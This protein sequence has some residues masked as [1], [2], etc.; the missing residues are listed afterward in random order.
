[1]S[2]PQN[3]E[4]AYAVLIRRSKERALLGSCEM[5]LRWDERTY[6]PRGGAEHRAQQRALLAGLV[7]DR[8]TAP[9]I[10]DL[11]SQ[12][13]ESPLAEDPL[14]TTSANIREIRRGYDRMMK[15]PR[16]L[17]EELTR[18]TARAQQAWREARATSTFEMF[19]PHLERVV[20]L[21]RQEAAALSTGRTAYDALLDGYEPGETTAN[22]TRVFELLR[23]ELVHL[24]E[25]IVDSGKGHD[26]SIPKGDYPLDRQEAFGKAAAADGIS[27]GEVRVALW[28]LTTGGDRRRGCE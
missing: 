21:K 22:L 15:L 8:A 6:M 19:C 11:L 17:V 3:P 9:E 4:D 1:M 2:T 26:L 16:S 25:A 10:E 13:E 27:E 20:E 5:L 23:R 24:V 18:A 28:N 7:H 12:V 14:S